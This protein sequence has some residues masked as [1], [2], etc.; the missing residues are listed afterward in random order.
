M[1]FSS[2]LVG[3]VAVVTG[4][5]RGIGRATAMGLARAGANVMGV[6]LD[7]AEGAA[8]VTA[9]IEGLGYVELT[10]YD[11]RNAR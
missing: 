11:T 5:S 8:G 3:P 7:D 2:A 6:H 10:G 9:A 1:V 4:V